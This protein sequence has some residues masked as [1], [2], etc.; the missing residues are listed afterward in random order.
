MTDCSCNTVMS[1]LTLCLSIWIFIHYFFINRTLGLSLGKQSLVISSHKNVITQTSKCIFLIL[2]AHNVHFLFSLVF[3]G[4]E[5][6]CWSPDHLILRSSSG[7]LDKLHRRRR[8][9][10]VPFVGN[11]LRVRAKAQPDVYVSCRVTAG[12]MHTDRETETLRQT[13]RERKTEWQR[14]IDT[15]RETGRDSDT[16]R[17]KNGINDGCEL[18]QLL[19]HVYLHAKF[20]F[21]VLN[22]T[23]SKY[24]NLIIKTVCVRGRRKSL[25]RTKAGNKMRHLL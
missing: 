1:C 25:C 10:N 2:N 14:N 3:F 9:C 5:P 11:R 12:G 15:E 16:E 20:N 21:S 19:P 13:Y 4:P 6:E 17:F 24:N 7:C 23:Y 18:N 22:E 8:R